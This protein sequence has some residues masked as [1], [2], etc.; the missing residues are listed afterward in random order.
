MSCLSWSGCRSHLIDN[1]LRKRE[2]AAAGFS[3]HDGGAPPG[4][5]AD[6]IGELTFER[7]FVRYRDFTAFDG[8]PALTGVDRIGIVALPQPVDFDLLCG[9]VDRHVC[10]R[11]EKPDL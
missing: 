8:R 2:R 1:L 10:Q 5:R 9:V 4:D 7:L 6:E 3:G 11:L